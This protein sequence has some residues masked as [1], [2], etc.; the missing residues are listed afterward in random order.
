MTVSYGESS[1]FS[2]VGAEELALV[3]GGKG[4]GGGG[5]GMPTSWG[6]PVNDYTAA[7]IT[8]TY[9]AVNNAV[10]T[11]VINGAPVVASTLIGFALTF[12]SG[13]LSIVTGLFSNTGGSG[14][15]LY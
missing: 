14:G 11:A 9:Y 5:G 3:N 7:K 8:S 15:S 2:A 1:G 4:E 12:T 13:A 6:N 10:G